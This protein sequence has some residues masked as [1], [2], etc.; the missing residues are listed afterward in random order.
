MQSNSRR[1]HVLDS[2]L[3][4]KHAAPPQKKSKKHAANPSLH[5]LFKIVFLIILFTLYFLGR[6]LSIYDNVS[7]LC[8]F[9]LIFPLRVLFCILKFIFRVVCLDIWSHIFHVY[10]FRLVKINIYEQRNVLNYNFGQQ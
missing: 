4:K 3:S 10:F 2:P 9:V 8:N 6:T 1:Y 5:G 7:T